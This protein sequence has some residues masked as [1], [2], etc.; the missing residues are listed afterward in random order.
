MHLPPHRT[1]AFLAL[2]AA[3]LLLLSGCA[4]AAPADA[5]STDAVASQPDA[6][7]PQQDSPA[8][9]P[10][11]GLTG[12]ALPADWPVDLLLPSGE[13]VLALN[14][15]GGYQLLI[16]GVD[17]AEA[18]ALLTQMAGAGFQ[19]IGPIETGD[20][21]WSA[22]VIDGSRSASYVYATGGAGEAN[23]AVTALLL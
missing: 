2:A 3:G 6:A 4:G 15:G 9:A 10:S 5:P 22:E 23:V 21:T 11:R 12:Q 14:V 20:G 1:S 8:E 19:L 18:R 16:E 13:L 7:E 17:E